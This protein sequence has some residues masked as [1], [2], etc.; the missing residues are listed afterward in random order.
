MGGDAADYRLKRQRPPANHRW[1][2]CFFNQTPD[3][4]TRQEND[5]TSFA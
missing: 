1:R 4:L 3:I 2:P 5:L